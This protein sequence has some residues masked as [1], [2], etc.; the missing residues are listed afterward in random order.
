MRKSCEIDLKQTLAQKG[1]FMPV[2]S[3]KSF[4]MHIE[5]IHATYLAEVTKICEVRLL[6]LTCINRTMKSLLKK[7]SLKHKNLRE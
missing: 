6:L 7:T 5:I 1:H 2:F 4:K 3:E